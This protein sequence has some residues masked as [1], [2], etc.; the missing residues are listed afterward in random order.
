[1]A[2]CNVKRKRKMPLKI[3]IIWALAALFLADSIMRTFRSNFNFG[4][5]IMYTITAALWVYGLFH[6]QID[7]FCAVGF[8]KVLKILFFCGMGLFCILLGFVAI[9]GYSNLPQGNEKAVIVLGAGLRKD[10]P[11]NLLRRRLEKAYEYHLENPEAWVVVTGGQG[12]DET[13]P[14]GVAMARWLENKG[15]PSDKIII[16]DKSTSTEENL[17]FARQLLEEKGVSASD[18][19]VVVTNAFHCYRG[20]K[21]AQMAGFS[22]VDTLPASIGIYSIMPCYFREVF[23]VLY[24]WVFKSSRSG[25]MLPFVGVF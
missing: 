21:Y 5:L 19:V 3:I 20:G 16:E 13:I 22:D 12:K 7:A 8:G 4:I 23:A 14:E 24:Y 17:L 2:L 9:S 25:W 1:M 15:V 18:P 6:K 10:V 11:S